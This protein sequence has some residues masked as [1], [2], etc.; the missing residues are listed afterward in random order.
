MWYYCLIMGVN[1]RTIRAL[2][3]CWEGPQTVVYHIGFLIGIPEGVGAI[4]ARLLLKVP[5]LNMCSSMARGD[6]FPVC[7]CPYMEWEH[8]LARPLEGRCQHEY[9]VTWDQATS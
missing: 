1:L 2:I 8:D 3:P 7:R 4:Q 6:R 5:R 9:H